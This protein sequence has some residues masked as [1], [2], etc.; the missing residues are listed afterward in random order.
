MLNRL[1]GEKPESPP[2]PATM[3]DV[4]RR[5]SGNELDFVVPRSLPGQG[6]HGVVRDINRRVVLNLIR[7]HQ[8]VSR[9][10]IARLCGLQRSTISQIVE[11]L[12]EESWI[13]EVAAERQPIGRQPLFF[14]IGDNCFIVGV[15]IRSDHTTVAAADAYG[16]FIAR[17]VIARPLTHDNAAQE[18]LQSIWRVRDCC[19]GRK[20]V[21]VGISLFDRDLNLRGAIARATGVEVELELDANAC[22]L[23]ARWFHRLEACRNLIVIAVSEVISTGIL[24]DGQL[25]RG[26]GGMAGD[27]GHF[28]LDPNGPA[29]RCGS[30]GCWEVYASNSAAIQTYLNSRPGAGEITFADLLCRAGHGDIPASESLRAMASYLGRGIRMIVAGLAPERIVVVGEL[31][32]SWSRFL[33]VIKAEVNNTGAVNLTKAHIDSF[34]DFD[35]ARLRGAVALVLQKEF[36]DYVLPSLRK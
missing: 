21:G 20:L 26:A 14:R 28:P 8:P 35:L 33:K 17:D 34:G 1:S 30:R 5:Q 31:T 10:E 23:A 3:R 2:P 4:R 36:G 6:A 24:I 29:C 9:A 13:S 27:F 12:I 7:A 25:V 32:R 22:V 15:D 16:K 18:I 11:Q 19:D